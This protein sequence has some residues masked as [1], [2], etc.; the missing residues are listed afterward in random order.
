MSSN[1]QQQQIST[2]D[3]RDNQ[4]LVIISYVLRAIGVLIFGALFYVAVSNIHPNANLTIESLVSIAIEGVPDIISIGLIIVAVI[5]VISL[6]ELVHAS[7]FYLHTGAPP[8]IGIRGVIVFASAEGYMNTRNAMMVNALAPFI[9]ISLLSL[10]LMFVIPVSAMA[11][12]FIPAVVNAAA[13]GGDFMAVFWLLRL[14]QSTQIE[15]HGD[16]MIAYA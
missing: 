10:L 3:F 2:L 15:D 7:V 9:V 5:A 13:A 4:T 8:K 16:V 6:H 14:P 1:T 12:I 11:W